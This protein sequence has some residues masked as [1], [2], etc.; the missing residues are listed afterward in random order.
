M[1]RVCLV[2]TAMPGT[3]GSMRRY[4]DL[5]ESSLR[6]HDEFSISRCCITKDTSST[7]RKLRTPIHHW[8]AWCGAKQLACDHSI[9]LFHLID[10][11]HGYITQAFTK[12]TIIATVHDIIPKLQSLGRF[13][14]PRPR[15]LSRMIIDRAISGLPDADHLIFDSDC[16]RND[17]HSLSVG[18]PTSES[19]IYPP[20][21]ESFIQTQS[22]P[23]P[24]NDAPFVFH[25]GNNGFY[26]NR[27]GVLRV[28]ARIGHQIPHR[29]VMA[30]PPASAD[31]ISLAKT[32]GISHRV[33]FHNDPTDEQVRSLY[34]CA[35]AFIFPSIYEGFGWP[36]I[37][38]MASGCPVVCSDGGSLS[39]VVGTAACVC[40]VGDHSA[41]ANSLFRV[42]TDDTYRSSLIQRGHQWSQRFSLDQF[43][44]RL[45]KAY[46]Q[47]VRASS[48]KRV[49]VDSLTRGA[50]Q[51]CDSAD[52]RCG[53]R[54]EEKVGQ[55]LK[56]HRR[57]SDRAT[58]NHVSTRSPQ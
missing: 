56:R 15:L 17:C 9:D 32:L 57:R 14:V 31:L 1:I 12:R 8:Y 3:R 30:G 28:F 18:L 25:L 40:R 49:S 51:I 16:T 37:E 54:I 27:A 44:K 36:P 22:S 58:L 13:D 35:S 19:V 46:R 24:H 39:E 4:A 7:P 48:G 29:L 21:E 38:A 11:S 52:A 47:A 34:R 43:A 10:G 5:V 50:L 26:K 20:I 33:R 23:I 42:L 2:E 53:S 6:N 55:D 41:M 45:E